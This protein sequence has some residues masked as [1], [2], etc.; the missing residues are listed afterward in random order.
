MWLMCLKA[1]GQAQA[2]GQRRGAARRARLAAVALVRL[3]W[4][5]SSTP[6]R[7]GSSFVCCKRAAHAASSSAPIRAIRVIRSIELGGL[8]R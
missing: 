3:A 7:A 5:T 6:V 8:W 1:A 2:A 4:L